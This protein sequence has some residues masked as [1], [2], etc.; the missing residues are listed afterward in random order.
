MDFV[1]NQYFGG[2]T[3]TEKQGE[4]SDEKTVS[5]SDMKREFSKGANYIDEQILNEIDDESIG[6]ITDLKS[7]GYFSHILID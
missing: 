2:V 7:Q 1:D 5:K 6:T 3:K 4:K